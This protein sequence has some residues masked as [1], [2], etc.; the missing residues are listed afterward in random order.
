ML[1]LGKALIQ[2]HFPSPK[3]RIACFVEDCVCK[4]CGPARASVCSECEHDISQH[5]LTLPLTAKQSIIIVVNRFYDLVHGARAAA[6]VF[7]YYHWVAPLID[8]IKSDLASMQHNTA[9]RHVSPQ[10]KGLLF[11]FQELLKKSAD[12]P[13]FE[14]ASSTCPFEFAFPLGDPRSPQSFSFFFSE[15]PADLEKYRVEMIILL[16]GLYWELYHFSSVAKIGLEGK[17]SILPPEQ[18]FELFAA[19]HHYLQK[20]KLYQFI[21]QEIGP[22]LR[23]QIEAACEGDLM[24]EQ[25]TPKENEPSVL[26]VWRIK[27]RET[28]ELFYGTQFIEPEMSQLLQKTVMI[29]AKIKHKNLKREKTAAELA[30]NNESLEEPICFDLLQRWRDACRDWASVIY[31]Y[32]VPNM[33]ALKKL[34]ELSPI[35]EMGAGTGYWMHLLKTI[36]PSVDFICYD[37][38]PP[39]PELTDNEFHGNR[40]PFVEVLEGEPFKLLSDPRCEKRTLFLCYPPPKD[41][42]AIQCLQYFTGDT[43]VFDPP[44]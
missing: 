41:E 30:G 16:D 23:K 36:N 12:L 17:L 20:R 40:I 35:V 28:V 2:L 1:F 33:R 13:T 11:A 5:T 8:A 4:H 22:K 43:F 32:A 24:E 15:N 29:A 39:R 7:Q 31:A 38:I 44:F 9:G 21:H 18:Y 14:T 42:M 3:W 27:W 26:K 37:T 34:A 25:A 6:F 10:L 19:K